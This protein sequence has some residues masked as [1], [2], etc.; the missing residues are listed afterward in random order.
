MTDS[1]SATP[2]ST[3]L[4]SGA[5]P[6][7][8]A[9]AALRQAAPSVLIA[10]FLASLVLP[11]FFHIGPLRLSPYRLILLVMFFPLLIRWLGGQAGRIRTADILMLL[12][13]IWVAF[14]LAARH[15]LGQTFEFSGVFVMETFGAYLM[16][17]VLIRDLADF[18]YFVKVFS[19]I[20]MVLAP[21]ALYESL[22][23]RLLLTEFFGSFMQTHTPVRMDPRWGLERAQ[24]PFEH[25][26][27]YGVFCSAAFG[28]SIFVTGHGRQGLSWMVRPAG[29]VLATFASLSAGALLSILLQGGMMAWDWVLRTFRHRWTLFFGLAAAG[30]IALDIAADRSPVQIFIHYL[31]FSA[32]NAYIRLAI[33]EYGLDNVW[34]HPILG[35]GRDDWA[36]PHWLP[37]SVDSFWLVITMRH[38]LPGFFLLTGAW[39]AILIG[40]ARL[41]S[42]AAPVLAARKGL[43]IVLAGIAFSI[44]TVHLWN[45]TYAFLIFLFGS[46]AWITDADAAETSGEAEAGDSSPASPRRR[47]VLGDTH[48]AS[49]G[50]AGEGGSQPAGKRRTVL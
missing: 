50:P 20:V 19:A 35:L 43:L 38:G 6:A 23:G 45:A 15:G 46:A 42:A 5:R 12:F 13:C 2:R 4:R 49:G 9:G 28:L 39:L 41:K 32:H 36:R 37:A 30:Y 44:S 3:G 21:L 29:A 26:I 1:L 7:G 8:R 33:W 22:T 40:L 10:V 25:P 18:R 31:T 11:V 16:A 27:L 24:G 14:S 47:A 17:R 34:S 48:A